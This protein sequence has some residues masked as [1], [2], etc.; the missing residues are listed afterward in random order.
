MVLRPREPGG[1]RPGAHARLV[2]RGRRSTG[3]VGDR[4]RSARD[5]RSEPD[6]T[7]LH[8]TGGTHD[9]RSVTGCE[10]PLQDEVHADEVKADGLDR[11]GRRTP[12]V[13][14]GVA[15]DGEA[16]QPCERRVAVLTRENVTVD[17]PAAGRR[18]QVPMG[19][20]FRCGHQ[21]PA[22]DAR[23][24]KGL[25]LFLVFGQVHSERWAES[26]ESLMSIP[27]VRQ[28]G[29]GYFARETLIDVIV[30]APMSTVTANWSYW[31]SARVHREWT[32]ASPRAAANASGP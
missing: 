2:L 3:H 12:R 20:P 4:D 26:S 5:R 11:L 17:P 25:S 15:V 13:L 32:N 28:C 7:L 6:E 23:E 9:L 24:A 21:P 10:T 18:C 16:V 22:A 30:P 19:R 1:A 27:V 29:Q 31:N 14:D 8:P